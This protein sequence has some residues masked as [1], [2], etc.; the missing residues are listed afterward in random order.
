MVAGATVTAPDRVFYDGDCGFCHRTV[1]FLLARDRS[2]RAFRFSPLQGASCARLIPAS[3][4]ERLPD[5]LLVR[6]AD[7]RLLARSEA[8]LHLLRR[9]PP[10]WPAI[11]RLLAGIPRP[12]RDRGYD[13]IAGFRGRLFPRPTS[14]CPVLPEALRARFED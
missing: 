8:T 7:G 1:R 12:L 9:L 6:T 3:A 10:P 4:R 2:G 14:R 11:A 13:A 5:S